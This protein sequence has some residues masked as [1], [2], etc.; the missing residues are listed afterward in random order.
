MTGRKVVY[1][2]P[3]ETVNAKR[4]KVFMEKFFQG[5]LQTEIVKAQLAQKGVDFIF[6][7]IE[8]T[9]DLADWKKEMGYPLVFSNNKVEI[10]MVT[11]P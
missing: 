1:G 3:F 7:E 9:H 10:Y 5:K 4:E 6:Y 2:H 8:L 11:E